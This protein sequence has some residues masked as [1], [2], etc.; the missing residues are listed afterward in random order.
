MLGVKLVSLESISCR[1]FT[2]LRD[3]S[4][5][6]TKQR[7][8]FDTHLAVPSA[9]DKF[10]HTNYHPSNYV[11]SFH[12]FVRGNKMAGKSEVSAITGTRRGRCSPCA[13]VSKLSLIG[14]FVAD[15]PQSCLFAVGGAVNGRT[16]ASSLTGGW[17]RCASLNETATAFCS[18]FGP[19]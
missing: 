5:A 11:N 19:R 8:T 10:L 18:I 2:A 13:T 15:W 17:P 14:D 1:L 4:I 6:V 16:L 9:V 7:L 3:L 12:A